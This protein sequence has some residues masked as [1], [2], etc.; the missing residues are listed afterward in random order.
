MLNDQADIDSRQVEFDKN[1]PIIK[2]PRTV[3]EM[4]LL[5]A[6]LYLNIL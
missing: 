1:A 5:I 4:V 3:W 2:P 6:L